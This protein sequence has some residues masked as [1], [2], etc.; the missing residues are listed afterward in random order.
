MKPKYLIVL[1]V[2][3]ALFG[4]QERVQE[5]KPYNILCIVADDHAFQ[6][7]S[8]YG[9]NLIH[10]PNIDRLAEEGWIFDNMFVTN[11]ICGPS[12]ATLLTGAYSHKN[13]FKNNGDAFDIHQPL[14]SRE[15]KKQGYQT[16][17][18]GKWHLGVSPEDSFDEWV[19]LPGQGHYFNPD[20]INRKDTF[21]LDGYVTDLITDLAIDFLEDRDQSQP[22]VMVV[23]EKAPHRNWMP[24]L[25]DLG[26][27]DSIDFPLPSN[28]YD[29][30]TG[31]P[32]AADQD[33]SIAETMR[34]KEDLK[35]H[36]EYRQGGFGRLNPTQREAYQLYY[37]EKISAE[38]EKIAGDEKALTEWK[39]QRYLKDYL[40]CISSVDRNVGRLMQYLEASGLL[41]NT[42]VIYTSDQGFY[43]GEHGWFDKRFMYEESHKTPF[44]LRHPD[45]GNQG[46]RIQEMFAFVDLAPTFLD[47]AGAEIPESM[48]G[49]SFMPLFFK[50]GDL[51]DWRNSV[52]YHYYEYPQPHRVAPHFGIRTDR[53]KLIRFYG[54]FEH[55]ELFDLQQ[56][57]NEM[58]N[59]YE[60]PEYRQLSESLKADLTELAELYEDKEAL[61]IILHQ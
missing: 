25:Q 6:A 11:S 23:G 31:R 55:W 32:A 50:G 30:Y 49:R 36:L 7:I 48:Q 3:F 9:S 60:D 57:P 35:V 18:I 33:M 52:Y 42:I 24:D 41:E 20:F 10:T 2:A 54:P 17:W 27:F 56:D 8:A 22:F 5:K 1:G 51:P 61:D 15:M 40:A 29:D 45:A 21:R 13:G 16:A 34:L 4:C 28:F 37:D 47:L 38:Y 12:R 46:R 44:I 43:L 39:F 59:L 26:R 14:F 19:I 58:S 53:Y